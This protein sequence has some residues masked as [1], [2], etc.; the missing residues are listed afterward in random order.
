[1]DRGENEQKSIAARCPPEVHNI[2]CQVESIVR[3]VTNDPSFPVVLEACIQRFEFTFENA[4]KAIQADASAEGFECTSPRDC[5]RTAFKMGVLD[6]EE[7]SWLKMVEYRNRTSHTYHEETAEA[8]YR[9][10][11]GYARLFGGCSQNSASASNCASRRRVLKKRRP[12]GWCAAMKR[13]ISAS[14]GST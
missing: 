2:V 6:L 5:F 13:G 12:R 8:I 4:W 7:T 3:G 10:L 9:S 1:M 11:P 14:L